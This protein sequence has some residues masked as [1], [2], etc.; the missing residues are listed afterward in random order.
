MERADRD[1]ILSH[2]RAAT[3]AIRWK[4]QSTIP[5]L[6]LLPE[7]NSPSPSENHLKAKTQLRALQSV[8]KRQPRCRTHHPTIQTNISKQ[9]RRSI[10]PNPRLSPE[11]RSAINPVGRPTSLLTITGN[12][13]PPCLPPSLSLS[14]FLSLPS[15]CAVPD[16][17]HAGAQRRRFARNQMAIPS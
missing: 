12:C 11:H 2:L 14:L 5:K 13:L 7:S 6:A 8:N 15:V 9:R 16:M 10:R 4:Q 17:Y 1:G 3:K